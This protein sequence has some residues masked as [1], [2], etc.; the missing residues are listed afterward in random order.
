MKKILIVLTTMLVCG[1]PD[2]GRQSSYTYTQVVFN[3]VCMSIRGVDRLQSEQISSIQITKEGDPAAAHTQLIN[4][5][6]PVEPGKCIAGLNQFVFEPGSAYTVSVATQDKEYVSRFI[7]WKQN[8]DLMIK[9][10]D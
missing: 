6:E 4:P 3:Q 7:V 10:R 8:D 5:P 1:C 2:G 9:E